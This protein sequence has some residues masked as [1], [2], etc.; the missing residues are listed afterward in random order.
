MLSNDTW[1]MYDD[2]FNKSSYL[3]AAGKTPAELDAD[4]AAADAAATQHDTDSQDTKNLKQIEAECKAVKV[5]KY[6]RNHPSMSLCTGR[7]NKCVKQKLKIQGNASDLDTDK[8]TSDQLQK[9]LSGVGDD[10]GS[11]KGSGVGTDSGDDNT[12][13]YVI[14]GIGLLAVVGVVGF[15]MYR[16]MHPAVAVA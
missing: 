1:F 13:I 15:M 16:K 10:A 7:V 11:S 2:G 5:T 8:A 14:G 9:A 3:N 4:K 12:M 6:C